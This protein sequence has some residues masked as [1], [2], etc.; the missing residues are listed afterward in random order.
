MSKLV[1]AQLLLDGHELLPNNAYK[2][3]VEQSLGGHSAFSISF[4]AHATETYAGA[5]MQNSLGFIGKRLSIGLDQNAMQFTGLVTSVDLHKGTGAAGTLVIS[6]NGPSVLLAHS[7]HCLSYGEG[8]SFQQVARAT[9]KGHSTKILKSIMGAGTDIALPYT[10]QYNESD[11]CFLQRLCRRYGVWLYHNGNDF[12]IGRSGNERVNGTYGVDVL[13]FRLS[14]MLKS[15]NFEVTGLDWI[16]NTHLETPAGIFKA[17]SAHPYLSQVGEESDRVFT[18]KGNYDYT[19]G[20][21]EYSRQQGMDTAVKVTRLGCAAGRVTATGRSELVGL[22]VG[23]ILSLQG[24]NFSDA[25]KRDPLG[26]YDIIKVTHRFDHSG[27]YSNDF[28]AVP[29]GTDHPPCSDGFAT[30]NCADQRGLVFDNADPDGL[31]RVKVQFPWQRQISASTPWI[32]TSTPYAGSGRGF[33]FVPEKGEEVLVGFEG[34]NPEKPYV[35][36]AGF[37]ASSKSGFADKENNIKAIR[38]RSGNT[39]E[40]NDSDGGEMITINDKNNNSIQINTAE[41]KMVFTTQGD[42][43]F[44]AKNVR[45]NVQEDMDV[46]I[47]GSKRESIRGKSETSTKEAV[48][49]V[50]ETKKIFIGK[51]LEQSSGELVMHTSRGKMLLDS[52]GKI[53]VQSK[54]GTD[55]GK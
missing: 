22:C 17:K 50:S 38:T 1:S 14:T 24:L 54:E 13:S 21:H 20:Q 49:N 8:T 29:E 35:I 27:Q 9:L 37:N 34:G 15:S 23:D 51:K 16:G 12:C 45:F 41:G 10:V 31:G 19:N 42:M 2:V 46:E 5:L 39:I 43:E 32:K 47:G 3:T 4:P 36:G 48:E 18:K 30:P 44:N 33:Y 26:T 55:Y 11:L 6:G 40:L 7:V 52:K 53:T 28:E 25:S